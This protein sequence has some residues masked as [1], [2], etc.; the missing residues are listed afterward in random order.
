MSGEE[1]LTASILPKSS[2]SHTIYFEHSWQHKVT[3]W[4]QAVRLDQTARA[5]ILKTI[6]GS[7]IVKSIRAE[8]RQ[9]SLFGFE[10]GNT[11]CATG[12]MFIGL[13]PSVKNTD[14]ATGTSADVVNAV[15]GKFSFPMS[16]TELKTFSYEFDLTGYELDLAQDPRRGAGIV[17]WTGNSGIKKNTKDEMPIASVS[18]KIVVDCSEP[19]VLW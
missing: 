5:R 10:D 6:Y 1:G 7:V 2:T 3:L 19:S 18:W 17:L 8:M 11:L 4:R 16:S 9:D 14:A 15:P 13:V 12:H